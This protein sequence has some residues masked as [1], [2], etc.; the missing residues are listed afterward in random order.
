MFALILSYLIVYEFN[1]IKSVNV[2]SAWLGNSISG[3]SYHV[4][5]FINTLYVS[6]DVSILSNYII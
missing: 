2:S 6:A 5:D 3:N 4:S 1:L